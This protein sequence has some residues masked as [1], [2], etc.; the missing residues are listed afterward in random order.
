MRLTDDITF[1]YYTAVR[2]KVIASFNSVGEM[3]MNEHG[4]YEDGGQVGIH[5]RHRL[6]L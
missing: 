5:N 4:C 2:Y 1:Q 3:I 6:Q